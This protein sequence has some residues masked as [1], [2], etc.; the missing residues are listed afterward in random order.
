MWVKTS[1]SFVFNYIRQ[2]TNYRKSNIQRQI[3]SESWQ[4]RCLYYKVL[5]WL[6]FGWPDAMVTLLKTYLMSWLVAHV[7]GNCQSFFYKLLPHRPDKFLFKCFNS[8]NTYSWSVRHR[9]CTM[10]ASD[11]LV[12]TE[13]KRTVDFVP[14]HLLK[15]LGEQISFGQ[16]L[17]WAKPTAMFL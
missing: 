11:K 5:F 10:Q 2:I 4:H 3:C 13:E 16:K 9:R 12:H 7:L 6:M 14:H 15:V 1:Y 17:K 8:Y